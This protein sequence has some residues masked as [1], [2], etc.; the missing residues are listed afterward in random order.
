MGLT[1]QFLRVIG[2]GVDDYFPPKRWEIAGLGIH[3]RPDSD[4]ITEET[5]KQIFE[6]WLPQYEQVGWLHDLNGIYVGDGIISGSAVG[7]YN[8]TGSIDLE[9]N[10]PIENPQWFSHGGSIEGVLNHEM[11]HHAHIGL[12]GFDDMR[13]QS[14][15]AV[16]LTE[17]VSEYAGLSICE[18]VAEIGAGIISGKEYPD[19][20]HEH[21]KEHD[22][23]LGVY[24]VRG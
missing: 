8:H 10:M 23:P 7:R 15:N 3:F 17:D 22:G 13:Q 19:W 16:L 12:N 2:W 11:I 1:Q 21:Y 5:W 14:E 24:E 9:K 6:T 18:S 20:V 4:G